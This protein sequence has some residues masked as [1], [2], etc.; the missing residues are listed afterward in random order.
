MHG[1][2]GRYRLRRMAEITELP[3]DDAGKRLAM[4]VEL[5]VTEDG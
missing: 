1:N 5:A 4:L 3:L 2:T